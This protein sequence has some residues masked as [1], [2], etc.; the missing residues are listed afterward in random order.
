MRLSVLIFS[1]FVY[2]FL[3]KCVYIRNFRSVFELIFLLFCLQFSFMIAFSL[4]PILLVTF[5]FRNS[6]LNNGVGLYV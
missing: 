2:L 3:F 5:C 4:I 6:F 1:L